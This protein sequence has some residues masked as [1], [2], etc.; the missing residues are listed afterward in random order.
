MDIKQRIETIRAEVKGCAE[1]QLRAA[2][3]CDTPEELNHF[4]AIIQA[5]LQRL[6]SSAYLIGLALKERNGGA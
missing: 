6:Q 2:E 3:E 1:S 4:N 5:A